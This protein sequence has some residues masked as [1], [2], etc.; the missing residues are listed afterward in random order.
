MRSCACMSAAYPNASATLHYQYAFNHPDLRTELRWLPLL[1]RSAQPQF[2]S[3]PC[4]SPAH[5]HHQ[6]SQT[7][8]KID[9]VN[10]KLGACFRVILDAKTTRCC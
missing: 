8:G 2:T 7:R 5:T 4:Q 3:Q 9:V 6:P 10:C 1:A